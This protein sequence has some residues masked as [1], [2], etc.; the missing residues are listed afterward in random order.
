MKKAIEKFR[1]E[2]I[3]LDKI[4]GGNCGTATGDTCSNNIPDDCDN[5]KIPVIVIKG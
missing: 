3:K 1:N 4:T 5:E 2:E